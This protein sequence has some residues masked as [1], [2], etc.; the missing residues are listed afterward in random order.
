MGRGPRAGDTLVSGLPLA[1]APGLALSD[2]MVP[3]GAQAGLASISMQVARGERVVVLGPSGAGKSTLL[4]AVAGLAPV[5][6]GRIE[7]NG[8]DVGALP[9]ERRDA[10]YLH[11]TPVLFPHLSVGENVAF[12]LRVRGQARDAV[13]RRVAEALAAVQLPGL[14]HRRPA[15]LS[16]GQRHR[17]ALARAIAARP[18]VL[19]LDEPLSALDPSLRDDVRDAIARA[20]AES[21]AAMLLVT[22][23]LEDAGLLG[24][25]VAV[26]LDG[27]VAQLDSPAALFARPATLAVARFLGLFQELRGRVADDR[28]VRCVAGRVTLP[29]TGP[30]PA[31]GDRVL[32][33]VRAEQLVVERPGHERPAH[34]RVLGYRTRPAGA[35]FVLRTSDDQSAEEFEARVPPGDA[36]PAI[37]EQLSVRLAPD[38]ALV[39]PIGEDDHAR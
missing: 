3:F 35:T 4:R 8:R 28:S 34:A 7:V 29:L 27:R 37:G 19:L 31:A 24:D 1:S 38:S 30:V 36:R 26:L 6:R 20:H 32:V 33:L 25:R 16:G 13:R 15:S 21:G 18:A 23:D 14:E 11:Q 39:F 5:T 2:L 12:P 22:H 10:V 9:A 17:V